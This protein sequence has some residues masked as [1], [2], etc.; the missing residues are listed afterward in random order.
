MPDNEGKGFDIDFK[1]L[2]PKLEMQL[3]VLA[4][5]A[6]TSKV[7]IAYKS[8]GFQTGLAYNYG[9]N[10]EAS[11]GVRRFSTTLGVN[12]GNGNLNLGVVYQ[13]FKFGASAS[14]VDK[15]YGLNFGFGATLLPFPQEMQGTFNSAAFGLQNM[16]GDI[17]AAPNNPLAWYKLHSDDVTAISNAV[18]LGQNI[19]D[20]GKDKNRFGANLRLNYNPQGGFLI[21]GAVGLRF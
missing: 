17:N 10:L 5:D 11:F 20:S 15:A 2:P 14:F 3:W 18:S 1:L 6:N 9:G 7:N 16:L 19:A 8:G 12:P 4:L 21:Y 13:G